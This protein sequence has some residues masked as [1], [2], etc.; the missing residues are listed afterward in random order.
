V[1]TTLKHYINVLKELK[2]EQLTNQKPCRQWCPS[3]L[4]NLAGWFTIQL[5]RKCISASQQNDRDD[6]HSK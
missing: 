3:G 2:I 5:W 6:L 1:T 4:F